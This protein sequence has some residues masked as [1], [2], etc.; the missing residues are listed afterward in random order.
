MTRNRSWNRNRNRNQIKCQNW[1]RN[2]LQIFGFR[3][4][5]PERPVGCRSQ[6]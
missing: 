2:C 4:P 3:N 1:D 6:H 5:A